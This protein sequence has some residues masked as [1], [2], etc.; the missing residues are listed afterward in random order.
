MRKLGFLALALSLTAS[1]ACDDDD[2]PAGPS[3]TGPIVFVSQLS[4]AN[5][6]P[7]VTNAEISA[8]GSVTITVTAPRD[9]AGNPT[10]AGTGS[11]AVQLNSFPASTVAAIA[12]HIHP[13]AAGATGGILIGLPVSAAAPIV[14]TGGAATVTFNDIAFTQTQ[15]TDIMANPA[16]FY[17]NVHTPTNGAGAVRGQLSR[18]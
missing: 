7:A 13:G 11:F 15:L 3:P 17:F 14:L 18:Q 9:S 16:N 2:P 5:E 12:A 8:R 1:A 10:G 6:I 4:A